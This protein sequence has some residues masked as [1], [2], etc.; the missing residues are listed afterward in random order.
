[1][2]LDIISTFNF[3][4]PTTPMSYWPY[5]VISVILYALSLWLIPLYMRKVRNNKPFQS[6]TLDYFIKM[7]NLFLSALSVAMALG[8]LLEV[9]KIVSTTEG[10]VLNKISAISCDAEG[11]MRVGQIPFWL[12]IFYLS[13]YYELL[14]TV[15]IMIKCKPLTFLHTFHHMSTL[16]LCWFV[17]VEKTHMMWYPATLN[18]SVHVVMYYYYYQ[19]MNKDSS[20]V[21]KS[22]LEMIK[23]WITRIQIIQF[24]FDILGTKFWLYFQYVEGKQCSGKYTAFL[25]ADVIIGSFLLLFLNFYFKAYNKKSKTQ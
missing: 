24:V 16:L 21:P 15:F 19:S 6:P 11:V 2:S 20:I 3:E 17:L 25:W 7:H 1:M 8:F 12:Y 23:P 9:I 18:S 4:Y 22:C 10:G 13:K 5:P 14:D